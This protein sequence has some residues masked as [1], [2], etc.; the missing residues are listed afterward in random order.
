MVYKTLKANI[1]KKWQLRVA[2]IIL[3]VWIIS[4]SHNNT[5]HHCIN[6]KPLNA[7]YSALTKKIETNPKASK[8][9]VNYR[10]RITKYKNIF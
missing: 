7:D 5:Y 6:K 2:N 4:R 1:Y 10:V 8:F 9:K 3:L